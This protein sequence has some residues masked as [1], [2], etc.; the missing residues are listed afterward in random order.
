MQRGN[1]D[2]RIAFQYCSENW[3]RS[4]LFLWQPCQNLFVCYRAGIITGLADLRWLIPYKKRREFIKGRRE[5]RLPPLNSDVELG[6]MPLA[7]SKAA[8]SDPNQSPDIRNGIA[9]V[10]D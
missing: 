4:D 10:G 2:D 1:R 7:G 3:R 9:E 5:F 8:D 6:S